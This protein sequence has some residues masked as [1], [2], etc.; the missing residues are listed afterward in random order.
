[1]SGKGERNA[2]KKMNGGGKSGKERTE[3]RATHTEQTL[4]DRIQ[5]AFGKA[6]KNGA[7]R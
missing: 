4:F 7:R 1:M 6:V 3:P 2:E 5:N